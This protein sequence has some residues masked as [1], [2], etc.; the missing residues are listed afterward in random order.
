MKHPLRAA[1]PA[2]LSIAIAG[3]EPQPASAL[4]CATIQSV[5]V[6]I[7]SGAAEADIRVIAGSA[8]SR[9][10]SGISALAGRAVPD[11][12]SYLIARLPG[13]PISYVV[14]FVD[15]CATHHGRFPDRLLRAWIDGSPA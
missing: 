13:A 2:L 1:L 8:A 10:R 11:G 7:R 14:R 6:Q 15:G 3:L 4:D 5:T 12:G 9:L